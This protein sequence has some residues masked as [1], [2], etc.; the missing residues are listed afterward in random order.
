METIVAALREERRETVRILGLYRKEYGRLPRGSFFVRKLGRNAY[1]YL[2]CSTKG[3]V[4]QDYLGLL[5]E[6]KIRQFREQMARKKKLRELMKRAEAQ[7]L[8]LD[9]ALRYAGKKS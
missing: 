1:G 4:K 9:R 8:F 5:A 6:E 7:Q 2:T 3:I